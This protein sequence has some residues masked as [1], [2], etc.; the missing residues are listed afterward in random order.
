MTESTCQTC[1]PTATEQH[2]R[3]PEVTRC[4]N[5]KEWLSRNHQEEAQMIPTPGRIVEYALTDD[6]AD[7][8]NRRRADARSSLAA[9]TIGNTGF[10]LHVGNEVRAG[11]TYPLIITRVWASPDGARPSTA[12]NGQVLLDGND[13]LWVTSITQGDG[14]R[15]WRQFPQV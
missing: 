9:G 6:D 13:T 7:Q 5:C 15:Q 10:S 2:P 14:E 1:G 11:D 4:H 8:I 3:R 12:L